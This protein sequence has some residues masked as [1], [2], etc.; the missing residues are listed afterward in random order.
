MGAFFHAA[1]KS[2]LG[3]ATGGGDDEGRAGG[4]CQ[5]L[6]ASPLTASSTLSNI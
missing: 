6:V 4:G 5:A 1:T 3:Q 2:R